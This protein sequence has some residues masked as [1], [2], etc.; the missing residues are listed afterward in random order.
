[1]QG[2]LPSHTRIN[3]IA[4]ILIEIRFVFNALF[5]PISRN[6]QPLIVTIP[7]NVQ[8]CSRSFVSSSDCIGYLGHPFEK[9]TALGFHHPPLCLYQVG[10]SHRSRRGM[11]LMYQRNYVCLGSRPLGQA[12]KVGRRGLPKSSSDMMLPAGRLHSWSRFRQ[13]NGSRGAVHPR[14]EER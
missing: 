6:S 1:M 9:E 7:L 11:F 14:L 8:V 12:F 2:L 13:P 5:T 10:L 3:A 4:Y